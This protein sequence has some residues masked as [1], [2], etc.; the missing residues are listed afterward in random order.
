MTD[1]PA[2]DAAAPTLVARRHGLPWADHVAKTS[3]CGGRLS[4]AARPRLL[5]LGTVPRVRD[6]GTR[7]HAATMQVTEGA[8]LGWVG[9]GP[10]VAADG[11]GRLDVPLVAKGGARRRVGRGPRPLESPALEA[12][13][14]PAPR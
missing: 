9:G 1:P 12:I 3:A 8:P 5:R 13:A 10:I 7:R 2:T 4:D 6:A 11:D 14:R